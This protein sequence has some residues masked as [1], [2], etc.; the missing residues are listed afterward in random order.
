LSGSPL[1]RSRPE[2]L[3]NPVVK[4]RYV[5]LESWL[6][7]AV[8]ITGARVGELTTEVAVDAGLIPRAA[9]PDPVDRLLVA[10]ARAI[11]ATFVTA[12]ARILDYAATTRHLVA[13]DTG[14]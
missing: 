2:P 11:D 9:L 5:S 1:E 4:P 8:E 10:T 6:R 12:D 3:R 14:R 13:R 7:R